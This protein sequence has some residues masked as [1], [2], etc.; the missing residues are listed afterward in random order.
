MAPKASTMAPSWPLDG[1]GL[2]HR[3]RI[4]LVLAGA[5]AVKRQLVEQMRGRRGG[6]VFGFGVAVGEGEGAVVRD[7][8]G[9]FLPEDRPRPSRPSRRSPGRRRRRFCTRRAAAQRRMAAGQAILFRDAKPARSLGR[10]RKIVDPRH[11][12]PAQGGASFAGAARR[13]RQI[14]AREGR[15]AA[16]FLRLKGAGRRTRQAVLPSGATPVNGNAA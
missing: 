2:G 6:V 14:A 8:A 1:V 9:A 4:G 13:L 11:C 16:L 5:M 12:K 7:M 10:R 3:P 15:G